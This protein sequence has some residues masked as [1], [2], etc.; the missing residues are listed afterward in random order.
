MR[1]VTAVLEDGQLRVRDALMHDLRLGGRTD[2][3]V[4]AHHDERWCGDLTQARGEVPILYDGIA[5]LGGL[6]ADERLAHHALGEIRIVGVEVQ[7]LYQLPQAPGLG[8]VLRRSTK[9]LQLLLGCAFA[10]SV[11]LDLFG[12]V[13][14]GRSVQQDEV[15]D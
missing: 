9:R 4:F 2:E 1:E 14:G 11:G 8:F 6:Y 15:A 10:A 12:V 3:V 13:E 7:G 5:R